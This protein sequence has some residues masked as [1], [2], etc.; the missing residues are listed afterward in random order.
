[1][2]GFV[3]ANTARRIRHLHPKVLRLQSAEISDVEGHA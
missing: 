2:Q 1:M 3:D